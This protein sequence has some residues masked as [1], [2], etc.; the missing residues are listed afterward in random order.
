M[1]PLDR[2]L[3]RRRAGFAAARLPAGARLLD[4]RAAEQ[5]H[6][7][8]PTDA[9]A[10]FAAAGFRALVERRLRLGASR[11]FRFERPRA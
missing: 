2:V 1:K 11:P 3:Q 4:G 8:D 10:P 6:G 9:H 7:I 5:R